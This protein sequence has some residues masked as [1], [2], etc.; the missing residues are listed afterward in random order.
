MSASHPPG[1]PAW[2]L[3]ATGP[4]DRGPRAALGRDLTFLSRSRR[5]FP[6]AT[7][8][9]SADIG[10]AGFSAQPRWARLAPPVLVPGACFALAA[11]S[12]LVSAIP[13]F[14][15]FGWAIWGRQITDPHVALSTVDGPS[16][17]PLPVLIT[18]PLSLLGD[19]APAGWLLIARSA[20]L[21]AVVL[22]YRL[23][24][25]FGSRPA[26]VLAAVALI[27]IPGWLQE[28]A[29]GGELGPLVALILG[30]IDRHVAK[31]PV[32]ALML[33]FGA[34]LLRTETW[35][36]LL[37]Y[38]AWLWHTN[39]VDRRVVAAFGPSLLVLW[40]VP[41]WITV[42][43]PFRGAEV[44]RASTEAR[45]A[46]FMDHPVLEVIKRAYGLVPL[47]LQLSA[48]AAVALAVRRRQWTVVV[49]GA[50]TLAWV[51]LVAAMA[52]VGGY[53]GLARF[54]VPAAAVACVVGAA[55]AVKAVDLAGPR[56]RAGVAVLLVVAL[57]SFAVEPANG[58]LD[59]VRTARSWHTSAAGL[60]VAVRRAGGAEEVG[61]RPLVIRHPG[62]TQLAWM[63][64]LPM[65][66]IRTQVSGDAL[67]FAPVGNP[68]P[69][70][71]DL[72]WRMVG[73]ARGWE[74]YEVGTPRPVGGCPRRLR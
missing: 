42:G 72:P 3:G 54:M 8:A 27:L 43:D 69:S 38:G 36:F 6:C 25:R 19:V 64:G 65:A 24:R 14:D 17:K 71:V 18:T 40:F 10:S 50:G 35:P 30:A 21:M 1:I 31:R 12:L 49:L 15:P 34:A 51:A 28:L 52:V 33:G 37:I 56:A 22:A 63:L 55:G 59:Q 73:R 62:L 11:L 4:R 23:G 44:A 2:A 67:V 53:T 68:P 5:S 61:C 48:L 26:G 70:S 46:A 39:T 16:W 7:T 58:L 60:E 66:R 32:Q 74:V 20:G 47:P 13:H 45:T 57:L 41:D 29:F 9:S